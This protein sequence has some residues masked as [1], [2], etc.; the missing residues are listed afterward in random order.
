MGMTDLQFK[1][2]VRKLLSMT[3]DITE[4]SS[5]EEI[6][7]IVNKLRR[8]LEEDLRGYPPPPSAPGES[9]RLWRAPA[10]AG[11]PFPRPAPTRR[12]RGNI[13]MLIKW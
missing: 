13:L 9:R 4:E 8:D 7:A 1:S 10:C 5:K 2:Y 6:L 12:G 11:V 3:E